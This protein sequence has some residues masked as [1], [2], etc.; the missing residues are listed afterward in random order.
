MFGKNLK[1]VPVTSKGSHIAICIPTNGLLHS[2]FAFFLIDAIRYTERQGYIVDI[3]MDLG[4][5]LSSQRQ[6]LARRAIN[7]H[8]A[9]YIMWFDSDMTFPEDTIVTLLERSKDVVCATYSKR[10]EPFHATA[11]EEINPFV[12]F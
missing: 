2:E 11:F 3:L 6:F 1:A 5:V 12:P 10:V 7:D 4:T 8:N 9:D